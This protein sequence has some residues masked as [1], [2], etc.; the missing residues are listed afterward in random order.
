MEDEDDSCN[1]FN[2]VCYT[3]SEE[4]IYKLDDLD[5]GSI[6]NV[7]SRIQRHCFGVKLIDDKDGIKTEMFY[8]NSD[9]KLKGEIKI[10][11][12]SKDD[13]NRILEII[14]S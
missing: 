7:I 14:N 12:V 10:P 5:N 9:D 11:F 13:L 6:H 1:K 8:I 4:D 3:L 2:D